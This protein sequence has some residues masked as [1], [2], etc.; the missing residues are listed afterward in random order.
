MVLNSIPKRVGVGYALMV[1]TLL[2]TVLISIYEVTSIQETNKDN[3]EVRFPSVVASSELL[4]GVS[5]SLS[6]LRGYLILGDEVQKELRKK[7]WETTISSSMGTLQSIS[8]DWKDRRMVSSLDEIKSRLAL[9]KQYQDEIESVAHT[10][11]NEPAQMILLSEAA[12]KADILV[13]RISRMIDIEESLQ[14]TRERKNLLTTLANFRGALGMSLASLRAYLQNG[15]VKFKEEFNRY[16]AINET[17]FQ[18]MKKQ[19]RLFNPEQL[20]AFTQIE[21]VRGEFNGLPEKMIQIRSGDKWNLANYWLEAKAAPLALEL[22]QLAAGLAKD[23]KQATRLSFEAVISQVENLISMEWGLLAIGIV[24]ALFISIVITRS[25]QQAVTKTITAAEAISAGDFD[26]KIDLKGMRE[27]ELLADAMR[28]MQVNL[29]SL[30][31]GLKEET[32]KI[33]ESNWVKSNLSEITGKLQGLSSL[34]SFATTLIHE[35]TP[36]VGGQLGLFYKASSNGNNT[37]SLLGSYAHTKRKNLSD[38]YRVGEGLVGQCALEQKPIQISNVPDDYVRVTSGLG[39]AIPRHIFVAPMVFENQVKGVIEIGT[40]SEISPQYRNLLDEVSNSLGVVI[41]S[42]EGRIK[43]EVLLKEAQEL[44]HQIQIQSEELKATNE[45]LEEKAEILKQNE[46]ELKNQSEE[47]QAQNE[48]L[49]EKT[50][51]LEEKNQEVLE[52]GKQVELFNKLLEDKARDLETASKYKSEFLANM[53]HE[54]RTPLNSLLILSKDLLENDNE[55]LSEDQVDSLKVINQGG[56]DL[57]ELI[58]DIL[59]LSKIEAGKMKVNLFEE[60]LDNLVRDI[61]QQFDPVARDRKVEFNV[62]ISNGN[63][64]VLNTDCQRVKQILKNLLSNAFKFT[65]EGSVTLRVSDPRHIPTINN[66]NLRDASCIA[67]SVV[68]TGVGI[69]NEGQKGIFEAFKQEDGSTSRKFGGTGLGLSI[70]KQMALLIGGDLFF[71]SEKGKGSHFTLCFPSTYKGDKGEPG[72][73]P[74]SR[75]AEAEQP[76]QGTDLAIPPGTES[77]VDSNFLEEFIPDDRNDLKP[78]DKSILI[79]EDDKIFAGVLAKITRKRNF[80]CISA[81]TGK[82]GLNLA[83]TYKPDAILL[84]LGLPDIDGANVLDQLKY[85][86]STRHIPIHVISGRDDKVDLLEKG[87]M[88]FLLKPASEDDLKNTLSQIEALINSKVKRVLIIEDDEGSQRAIRRLIT[89]DEVESTCVSTGREAIQELTTTKFDCVILDLRL[90]DTNGFELLKHLEGIE[91]ISLPPIVIYTGKELSREESQ[92]LQKYS[93]SIVVKG[94]NSPERLLDEVTLFLH[95]V[96]TKMTGEQKEIRVRQTSDHN[97]LKEK[98]VLIVDDDMR[99]TFALSK[100][101][102]KNGLTVS[103]ADNGQLALEKLDE[104]PN[105]DLV[106]MDIMMPVMDGYEAMEKIREQER[107]QDLP[108][109]ALTA[110]AMPEDRS[111]CLEKG[112]NDYVPKPV[113][114]DMLLTLMRVLLLVE[115]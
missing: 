56:R 70:S 54:L 2:A 109:I 111:R 89:S 42:I 85:N 35:L 101:L 49:E 87:A 21:R 15:D 64:E 27:M 94:A 17:A 5:K 34:E 9:L 113:E 78:G 14:A 115:K 53:S 45:E 10:P 108:I 86:P 40:F 20:E 31:Q 88:G 48:E 72:E 41:E 30:T 6:A 25:I 4:T 97:P 33:S 95:S 58:N 44:N 107:F 79:I 55:N 67:F 43:T 100:I 28:K 11:E 76:Q 74:V 104:N 105:I 50:S 12:P 81:G 39:E 29:K 91:E 38:V 26:F 23:N 65:E 69:S 66:P 112:A 93:R 114:V 98:H 110:K 52:K 13:A 32:Q 102:K 18:S 62:E 51:F 92:E 24:I 103:M 19:V 37:L 7:S 99:N 84:D 68:D 60:N 22:N 71:E 77:Q 90:P 75:P 96:E 3:I 36:K 8:N 47:L 1:F 46:E 63:V 61:K 106:L 16:W 83:L 80:K 73:H 82:G 59:D 57:L